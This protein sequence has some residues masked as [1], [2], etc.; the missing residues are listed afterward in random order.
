M[1]TKK[2]HNA[3]QKHGKLRGKMLGEGLSLLDIHGVTI[4]AVARNADVEHLA[5]ANHFST[6]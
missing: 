4:R 2:K 5:P 1:K 6:R 3:G